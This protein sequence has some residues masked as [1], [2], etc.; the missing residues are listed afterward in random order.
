METDKLMR[1]VVLLE[2][3]AYGQRRKIRLLTIVRRMKLEIKKINKKSKRHEPIN[4]N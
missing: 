1:L 2:A 4:Q 3:E